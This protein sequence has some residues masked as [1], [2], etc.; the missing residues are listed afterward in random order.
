[1]LQQLADGRPGNLISS[2]DSIS[3]RDQ[4]KAAVTNCHRRHTVVSGP[5]NSELQRQTTVTANLKSKQ[6]LLLAFDHQYKIYPLSIKA[7]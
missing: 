3:W 4:G 2:P 1:M 7:I 5:F 6:L